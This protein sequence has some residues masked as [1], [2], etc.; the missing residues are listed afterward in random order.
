M[1][2]VLTE[3]MS[4]ISGRL[5]EVVYVRYR[6]GTYI[7]KAPAKR[8]DANDPKMMLNQQR[9][10]CIT[11]FCVQF[12]Y[13]L[14]PMIWN[15]AATRGSGYNAFLKA[16]G[17]AFAKD[18]SLAD[19]LFITLSTG[20]LSIPATLTVQRPMP[21]ANAIQ[22]GWEKETH[23]SGIRST[24][25]LVALSYDGTRFS[26]VINTG[27]K[28]KDLGGTF[29]LPLMAQKAE[30]LYLFFAAQDRHHFSVSRAFMI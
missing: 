26:P 28:R 29:E 3:N 11:R 7:R 5:G 10:A 12:K 30:Y 24:D 17:P 4:A 18:G 15:D 8:K 27:I 20:H 23:L 21:E 2:R 13:T 25:E 9:F 22:V 14:I 6:G 1:A 19:A 16:N